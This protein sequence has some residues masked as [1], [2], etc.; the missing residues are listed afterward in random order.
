M[1]RMGPGPFIRAYSVSGVL[2]Y[3]TGR[4]LMDHLWTLLGVR[5]WSGYLLRRYTYIPSRVRVIP[6]SSDNEVTTHVTH[7]LHT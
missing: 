2:R 4:S 6:C 7:M 1:L 3:R 5:L